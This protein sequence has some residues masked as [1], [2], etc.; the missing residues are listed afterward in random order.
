MRIIITRR[1][2]GRMFDVVVITLDAA[3]DIPGRSA[4]SAESSL[5]CARHA[6]VSHRADQGGKSFPWI[7]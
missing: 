1:K 3:M 4:F 6:Q 2:N 5:G 7:I